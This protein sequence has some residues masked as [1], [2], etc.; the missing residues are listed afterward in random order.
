[1]KTIESCKIGIIYRDNWHIYE[2]II[3]KWVKQIITKAETY[4]IEWLNNRLRHCIAR[5]HR[6]T[7]CYSK[8]ELMVNLTIALFVIR[9]YGLLS[10]ISS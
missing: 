10:I 7:R 4:I 1:M 3:K 9:D 8:S 2:K 5:F 6:K